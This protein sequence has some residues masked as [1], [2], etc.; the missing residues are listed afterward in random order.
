VT[1]RAVGAPLDP[2]VAFA[3]FVI[4]SIVATLAW[5]PGGLGTFEGSCV[6]ML[7][8]HGVS[9]ESAMAGTL[10]LRGFSFWLP[11]LPGFA[12][13]RR[14]LAGARAGPGA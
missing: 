9:V 1:L 4:A 11:M 6:A 13:A 2:V 8:L 3:S 14:E 12:L 7:H 10:L 5:I